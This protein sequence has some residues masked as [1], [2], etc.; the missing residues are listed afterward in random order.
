MSEVRVVTS[1]QKWHG[2]HYMA[3]LT[4]LEKICRSS[5][6]MCRGIV[7]ASAAACIHDGTLSAGPK[8][9]S[10]YVSVRQRIYHRRKSKSLSSC[11]AQIMLLL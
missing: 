8:A 4:R 7:T 3:V 1:W 2:V 9:H 5:F 11:T 10:P 6:W